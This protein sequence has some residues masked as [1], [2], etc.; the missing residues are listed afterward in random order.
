MRAVFVKQELHGLVGARRSLVWRCQ[1]EQGSR[2][3]HGTLSV[4]VGFQ[5]AGRRRGAWPASAVSVVPFAEGRAFAPAPL[6]FFSLRPENRKLANRERKPTMRLR[7]ARAAASVMTAARSACGG[8]RDSTSAPSTNTTSASAASSLALVSLSLLLVLVSRQLTSAT[9]GENVTPLEPVDT[10]RIGGTASSACG[11]T[12]CKDAR[13]SSGVSR[14]GVPRD[15]S[16]GVD[17]TLASHDD[18]NGVDVN[19]GSLIGSGEGLR[20]GEG[21]GEGGSMRRRS[22][23]STS[24][25]APHESCNRLAVITDSSRS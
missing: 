6:V 7:G 17:L 15:R 3:Q 21:D 20:G 16:S 8:A 10:E 5:H 14:C 13:S 12:S 9:T 19:A 24:S 2:V 11:P 4:H 23:S 1:R 22:S 25:Q 18:R